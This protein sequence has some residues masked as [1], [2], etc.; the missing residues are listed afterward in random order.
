[1]KHLRLTPGLKVPHSRPF[2]GSCSAFTCPWHCPPSSPQDSRPS[3]GLSFPPLQPDLH[4]H[5]ALILMQART[6]WLPPVTAHLPPVASCNLFRRPTC[7]TCC[8]PNQICLPRPLRSLAKHPSRPYSCQP[9]PRP[10][11]LLCSPQYRLSLGEVQSGERG[12]D[13]EQMVRTKGVQARRART[14]RQ[15]RGWGAAATPGGRWESQ[16]PETT[17]TLQTDPVGAGI[18]FPTV[19]PAEWH[20]AQDRF[21]GGQRW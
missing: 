4:L 2:Q 17:R 7:S 19:S 10:T 8:L 3:G 12:R 18:L 21:G 1:M 14:Q 15:D 5:S 20:L 11:Q 13:K 9:S 16:P 6:P